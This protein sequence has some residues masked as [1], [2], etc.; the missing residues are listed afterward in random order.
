MLL[1]HVERSSGPWSLVGLLHVVLLLLL[2]CQGREHGAVQAPLRVLRVRGARHDAAAAVDGRRRR[3]K[4]IVE[5]QATLHG[6]LLRRM[7]CLGGE[8]VVLT[9]GAGATV[10]AAAT[11]HAR[12]RNVGRRGTPVLNRLAWHLLASLCARLGRYVWLSWLCSAK[13][14]TGSFGLLS[15]VAGLLVARD[16]ASDELL[17]RHLLDQLGQLGRRERVDEASLR[18][19]E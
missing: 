1:S 5:R 7:L 4:V 17:A 16:A 3:A 2:V 18:D 13:L 9:A 6:V 11:L 14:K 12:R 15:C 19:D 10:A 8:L